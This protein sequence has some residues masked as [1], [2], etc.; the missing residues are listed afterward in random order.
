[1][2]PLTT[3]HAEVRLAVAEA[4]R[5]L[6]QLLA[7]QPQLREAPFPLGHQHALS[8]HRVAIAGD[9]AEALDRIEPGLGQRW[10]QAMFPE[11]DLADLELML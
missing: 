7:E 2:T 4:E 6:S 5:R 11:F 8:D 10:M 1:M 9:M 3:Q